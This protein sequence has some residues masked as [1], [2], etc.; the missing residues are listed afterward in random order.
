MFQKFLEGRPELKKIGSGLLCIKL[1]TTCCF[2]KILDI[3][4]GR[5]A[6][7]KN[8]KDTKKRLSNRKLDFSRNIAF[9][10]RN[11]G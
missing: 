9:C 3:K 4:I 1:S 5:I 11:C 7:K 10:V 8:Q 6:I 2:E